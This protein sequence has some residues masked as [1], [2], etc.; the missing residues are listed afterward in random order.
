MSHVFQGGHLLP[1]E[2]LDISTEIAQRYPN[3]RLTWIPPENRGVDD[4]QIWAIA[5]VDN[6]GKINAIIRRMTEFECHA[7]LIFR[8]LWENDGQRIDPWVKFQA[9]QAKIAEER[10]KADKE[11]IYERA[12]VLHAVASSNLH[13]YRINGRKIGADNEMPTLGLDEH[14][15]D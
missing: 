5:Q 6:E 3:L 8:W 7:N 1:Q 12:E 14:D 13:T 15:A 4:T 11:D 10:R 2:K 9:Q